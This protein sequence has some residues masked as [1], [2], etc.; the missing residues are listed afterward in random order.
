MFF[1]SPAKKE[2][3]AN[4]EDMLIQYISEYGKNTEL[5]KAETDRDAIL[6]IIGWLHF[7]VAAKFSTGSLKP[8]ELDEIIM[9]AAGV[10][11]KHA[12]IEDLDLQYIQNTL[13]WVSNGLKNEPNNWI[14]FYIE[15][16]HNKYGLPKSCV[17]ELSSIVVKYLRINPKI[18]GLFFDF[19]ELGKN[20]YDYVQNNKI[21]M[22]VKDT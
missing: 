1:S 13:N 14:T 11:R 3:L 7:A 9:A 21:N 19:S 6:V 4:F 17:I 12:S 20:V 18:S 10:V 5:K 15:N 8:K 2:I 22:G 16:C